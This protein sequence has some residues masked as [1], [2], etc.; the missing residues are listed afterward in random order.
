MNTSQTAVA[1]IL[2]P[3]L[4]RVIEALAPGD[5]FDRHLSLAR[6]RML[7]ERLLDECANA[8]PFKLAMVSVEEERVLRL[9]L[10]FGAALRLDLRLHQD[11]ARV[12]VAREPSVEGGDVKVLLDSPPEDVMDQLIRLDE[13]YANLDIEIAAFLLFAQRP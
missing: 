6:W 5:M 8:D 11:G 7:R 3:F 4:G 2:S 13:V 9:A 10:A 1:L 12:Y